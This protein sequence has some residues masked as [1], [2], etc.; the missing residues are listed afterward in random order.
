MTNPVPT[1]YAP[2][3]LVQARGRNWIVLPPDET[4]ALRLRPAEGADLDPIG[5]VPEL[6]RDAVQPATYPEPDPRAAGDFAGAQLVCDALRLSLRSGA[7]P[8]RSLG[9][10]SVRPRPYQFVPLIMALR[11]HPVRL[12]IADDVGVGKTIEAALV[13]RE[14]LDRGVARRLAVLCP[15]HLCEQW[16]QELRE[17]FGIETAVVQPSRMARLERNL[18]RPD[19][20]IFQYYRHLVASIDF[21]KSGRYRGPFIDNAPDLIIVDEAHGASRP[22]GDATSVQQQRYTFL[23]DLM[24]RG[25]DRHLILVTATPHSGIEESFRSLLGLLKPEFD[26]PEDAELPLRE[27]LPYVVQRRRRELERWMDAETPFPEREASERKYRL[28][29]RYRRLFDDVLAYCRETVSAGSDGASQRQRVRYWAAT[30]ILRCVLSSPAAAEA[31]LERR[32]QAK[33]LGARAR[34]DG[35]PAEND[36]GRLATDLSD[37]GEDEELSDYVP[38]SALDDPSGAFSGTEL[39]RL[40]DFLR[41][42]RALRGPDPDRKLKAAAEVVHELLSG[43]FRPIV[44]CKYIDTAEYVANELQRLLQEKHPDLRVASVT[45]NDGSSE[46]RAEKVA[47]LTESPVRVLVATECL[48]EG[49]NLQEHFDAVVH[50]DLP[51]NPNRLEQREGRVDRYGQKR[52]TVKTVLLYGEDN[53]ID[54]IVLDVLIRKA[55]TIR[56]RT[57]VSVPVPVENEQIV[58]AIVD[59]VLLRRRE[60]AE[61]LT[62]GLTDPRVSRL[63]E[64][65]ERA[66]EQESKARSFFAQEGIR[67]DQVARELQELEP[68]LGG[69][70]DVRR[71]VGNAV[72]RFNGA[73]RLTADDVYELDPGDL[74][75][76]IALRR[77]GARFP[78]RV[79]FD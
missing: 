20:A 79:A 56:Q 66:A 13:A 37:A 76:A 51:W 40:A 27:L 22:R 32:Q 75:G 25:P 47:E 19:V 12:L 44:F 23:R 65:W 24:D 1:L 57:G 59:S 36:V 67:P 77:P 14:L 46:Q 60:R 78:M 29:P 48:S 4:G 31:M 52:R 5:L 53:E 16:E 69:P 55:R 74:A 15:P 30:A 62:L 9:R 61:Q 54:L 33:R 43:G 28:D 3:S 18:P 21:V 49:I 50:Y 38:A 26:R 10:L 34:E 35:E 64:E 71:F 2:G 8:F 11:Q 41:Q 39:G 7:G 17:K 70:D 6:E 45:G 63:H 68:A 73:L 58:Q 42:A 72:Q